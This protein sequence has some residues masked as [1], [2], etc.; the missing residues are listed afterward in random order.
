MINNQILGFD[1]AKE[2]C[3]QENSV[4][5]LWLEWDRREAIELFF[6]HGSLKMWM[7]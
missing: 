2:C 3:Y 4:L 1:C 5:S 6:S 7:A